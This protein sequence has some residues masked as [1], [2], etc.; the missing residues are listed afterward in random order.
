MFFKKKMEGLGLLVSFFFN[1]LL[2][3]KLFSIVV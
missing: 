1:T 2:I 3:F